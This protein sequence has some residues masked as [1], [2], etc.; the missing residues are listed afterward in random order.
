MTVDS[1][2]RVEVGNNPPTHGDQTK[3][4]PPV[5]PGQP[6]QKNEEPKKPKNEPLPSQP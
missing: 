2:L 3:P 4:Q 6:A 1:E 5:Q